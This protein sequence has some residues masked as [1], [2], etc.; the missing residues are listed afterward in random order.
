MYYFFKARPSDYSVAYLASHE[1]ISFHKFW[2][3]NPLDIYKEWF[4]ESDL[5]AFSRNITKI[6]DE[7]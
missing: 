7:L 5:M 4:E 3:I 1:P 2:M 6:H